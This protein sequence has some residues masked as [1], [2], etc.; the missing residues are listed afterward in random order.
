MEPNQ[1]TIKD[2]EAI[3]SAALL[4]AS[5]DRLIQS[6]VQQ[7]MNNHRMQRDLPLYEVQVGSKMLMDIA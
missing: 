5:P 7:L 1:F 6:G 3:R 2:S 4:P